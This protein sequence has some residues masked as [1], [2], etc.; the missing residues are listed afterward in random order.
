[1]AQRT[2]KMSAGKIF[3]DNYIP[4]YVPED[5]PRYERDGL[6]SYIDQ[7]KCIEFLS[8]PDT[9]IKNTKTINFKMIHAQCKGTHRTHP[10]KFYQKV[11]EKDVKK[12]VAK[13]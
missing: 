2:R 9:A 1:M 8:D 5:L 13:R 4:E 10:N 3:T 12:N 11:R 7:L 6:M